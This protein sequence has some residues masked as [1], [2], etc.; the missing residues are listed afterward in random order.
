VNNDVRHYDNSNFEERFHKPEDGDSS[1]LNGWWNPNGGA[2]FRFVNCSVTQALYEDGTI[3]DEPSQDVVIGQLVAGP[4]DRSSGKLVDLDP[5][6][7]M[8]SQ[9]WAVTL[10]LST[11][12][13]ELILQGDI[14]PTAFRD[15]QSRQFKTIINRQPMGAS[16]TSVL[17]NLQWGA[18]VEESQVLSDLRR[19]SE[20]EGEGLLALNLSAFGYY[21]THE[22]GRFSMGRLLGTIAPYIENEPT[23]FAP[24]RRLLGTPSTQGFTYSNFLFEEDKNR[25]T[26]DLG[27]SIPIVDPLGTLGDLGRIRVAVA[28]IPNVQIEPEGE[29]MIAATDRE[30]IGEVNYRDASW[31]DN[32]AGIVCFS[33]VAASL[34][35]HQLLLLGDGPDDKDLVLACEST[36]GLAV[37]ANQN[38]LRIDP[39]DPPVTVDFYAYQWGRPLANKQIF[40]RLA[41]PTQDGGGSSDDPTPPQAPIPFTNWPASALT[42]AAELTT[43]GQ[44]RASLQITGEDPGNPRDYV[45]GQS[46]QISYQLAGLPPQQQAVYDQV[47]IHLRDHYKGPYN[48]TWADV[49]PILTQYGNLYPLM[50]KHIVDLSNKE[51]VLKHKGI[52]L[53]AFGLDMNDPAYMP[54]SRDLSKAKLQTIV[55]WLRAAE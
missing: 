52:L 32:T 43:D 54:V 44:G 10:R 47:M 7:Q 35:N 23:L 40:C 46:Y 38:V 14:E 30:I 55:K 19:L 1:V 4:R 45:D 13:N 9:L 11:A 29:T 6:M 25:L 18:L 3:V 34:T 41:W 31:L 53:Y 21:Y 33:D 8:V 51:E 50:S 17:R 24:T 2:T 12:D 15:I 20:S 16:W 5:Q 28:R 48:P 26:L 36:N 37:R 27:N 42:F 49:E 22:D 39:G